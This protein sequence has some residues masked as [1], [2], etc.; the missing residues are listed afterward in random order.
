MTGLFIC[1]LALCAGALFAGV[2]IGSVFAR[3]GC[4]L[5]FRK[6]VESHTCSSAPF[7][8]CAFCREERPILYGALDA[9]PVNNPAGTTVNNPRPVNKLPAFLRRGA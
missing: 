6:H 5:E 2:Y 9:K 7:F 8:H 4:I 3:K 1:L